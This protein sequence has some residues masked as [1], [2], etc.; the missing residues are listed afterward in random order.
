MSLAD[1]IRN[2]LV[3][4]HREGYRFIP[5]FAV[6]SAVLF[7]LHP[8]AGWIGVGYRPWR[9]AVAWADTPPPCIVAITS[10]MPALLS[11]SLQALQTWLAFSLPNCSEPMLSS[12]E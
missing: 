2:T 4:I 3:P 10:G 5:V 12:P 7:F 1:T 9:S 11:M 6:A 8:I